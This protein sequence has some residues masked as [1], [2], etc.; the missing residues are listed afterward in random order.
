MFIV[1]DNEYFDT[2][3]FKFIKFGLIFKLANKNTNF[4]FYQMW[5]V[6]CLLLVVIVLL[7]LFFFH[8]VLFLPDSEAF[9]LNQGWQ[10][11]C[12]IDCDC[13]PNYFDVTCHVCQGRCFFPMK[14]IDTYK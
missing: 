10:V 7:L 2:I 3:F 12:V 4:D 6:E 1:G 13:A 11:E 5:Q 14:E 9:G 8:F